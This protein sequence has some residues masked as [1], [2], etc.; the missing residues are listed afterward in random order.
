VKLKLLNWHTA[1]TPPPPLNSR[2]A[3]PVCKRVVLL[4]SIVL[5][6][7]Q[8]CMIFRLV[9]Y[10]STVYRAVVS[11]GPGTVTT[12]LLVLRGASVPLFRV[13]RVGLSSY[14]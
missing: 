2:G 3:S 4:S 1:L 7:I 5:C 11:Y 12:V 10:C 13:F 14:N 8:H 9:I 6:T